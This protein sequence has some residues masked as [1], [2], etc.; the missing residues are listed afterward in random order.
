MKA[1]LEKKKKEKHSWFLLGINPWEE[2]ANHHSLHA[3]ESFISPMDWFVGSCRAA[4]CGPV[5]RYVN[6]F[7][8]SFIK[9]FIFKR[10]LPSPEVCCP[11]NLFESI[12]SFFF[13]IHYFESSW[14]GSERACCFS[15]IPSGSSARSCAAAEFCSHWFQKFGFPFF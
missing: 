5:T 10:A 6:P 11:L 15:W 4:D 1:V 8:A 7:F 9:R 12:E 3:P 14:L 13:Y 2:Y